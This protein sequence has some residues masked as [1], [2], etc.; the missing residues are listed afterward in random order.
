MAQQIGMDGV[1]A[2]HSQVTNLY[3]VRA[4]QVAIDLTEIEP[5]QSFIGDL[6]FKLFFI[7]RLV[8]LYTKAIF[9]RLKKMFNG[10]K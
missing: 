1:G 5:K 9:R 10:S 4:N 2:T 6:S 8:V 7:R 3:K